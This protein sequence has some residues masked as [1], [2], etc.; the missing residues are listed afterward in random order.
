[1]PILKV[2]KSLKL[3]NKTWWTRCGRLPNV[4]WQQVSTTVYHLKM[5]SCLVLAVKFLSTSLSLKWFLM[6]MRYK[7]QPFVNETSLTKGTKLSFMV[8]VSVILKPI[9]KIC[10]MPKAIKSTAL[11]IQWNY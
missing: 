1:M 9:L 5:S 3:S 8:Q 7:Q 11:Q 4:N 2:L 10:M 6:M